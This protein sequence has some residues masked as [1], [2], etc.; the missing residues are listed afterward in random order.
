M[1]GESLLRDIQV[2]Y[3]QQCLISN[4]LLSDSSILVRQFLGQCL[5]PSTLLTVRTVFRCELRHFPRV[6]GDIGTS[7]LYVLSSTFLS[8]QPS[9]DD[10]V[11]VVSLVIWTLTA[12]LAIKY[13]L[14]VLHADDNGQGNP[15]HAQTASVG[16]N[17][18]PSQD[19]FEFFFQF[20]QVF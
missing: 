2:N 18:V 5:G 1:L 12:L 16:S 14:I 11:G 17:L 10:I 15:A 3:H 8:K 6:A 7:P 20:Q 13:T 4:K 9:E 19:V